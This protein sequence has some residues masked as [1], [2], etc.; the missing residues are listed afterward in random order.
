M[1]ILDL[2]TNET[3]IFFTTV[4]SVILFLVSIF[5][6][7]YLIL[8]LPHDYFTYE[9]KREFFK[10]KR[11]MAFYYCKAVFRNLL[12]FVLFIVGFILLFIPGQGLLTLFI[13]F[14]LADIPGKYKI[15]KYLIQ[16]QRIH[17]FL[18]NFREKKGRLPFEVPEE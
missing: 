14:L 18:N 7:P 15:E 2:F 13:A 4:F 16:K 3:F 12:A 5:Y 9:S 10:N 6:A 1:N 8:K 11:E 17:K